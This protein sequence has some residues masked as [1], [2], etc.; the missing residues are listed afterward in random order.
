MW[1]PNNGPKTLWGLRKSSR[2][3]HGAG[4][5]TGWAVFP[6]LLFNAFHHSLSWTKPPSSPACLSLCFFLPV[7]KATAFSPVFGI[8]DIV[9]CR[10][11]RH[12]TG[13]I[14]YPNGHRNSSFDPKMWIFQSK[15]CYFRFQATPSMIKKPLF[16]PSLAIEMLLCKGGWS[17]N[18]T[19]QDC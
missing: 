1:F 16:Q 11:C 12:V 18:V 17:S 13:E 3:L 2:K 19:L 7:H 9:R 10:R 4:S 5:K 8:N 14:I 6:G 15:L